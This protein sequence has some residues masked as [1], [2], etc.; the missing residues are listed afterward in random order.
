MN[1]S[2]NVIKKLNNAEFSF[3]VDW[4][5]IDESKFLELMTHKKSHLVENMAD[6]FAYFLKSPSTEVHKTIEEYILNHDLDAIDLAEKAGFITNVNVR[7]FPKTETIECQNTNDSVPFS[8]CLISEETKNTLKILSKDLPEDDY[9]ELKLELDKKNLYLYQEKNSLS[10]EVDEIKKKT[11]K[12]SVAASVLIASSL[13]AGFF[14]SPIIKSDIEKVFHKKSSIELSIKTINESSGKLSMAFSALNADLTDSVIN[15]YIPTLKELTSSEINDTISFVNKK[16]H[17]YGLELKE[18]AALSVDEKTQ[19]ILSILATAYGKDPSENMKSMASAIAIQSESHHLD[20]KMMLSIIKVESSF[21]QSVVSSTGDVSVA[22]VNYDHWSPEFKR[23]HYPNLDKEKLKNDVFYSVKIMA[24]ILA[25][26]SKGHQKDKLWYARYH[27][28]T[29]NKKI[30]YAKK[31][32]AE[33]HLIEETVALT[34][35]EKISNLIVELKNLK[36]SEKVAHEKVDEVI[37]NLTYLSSLI[38]WK[39]KEEL[40]IKLSRKNELLA[41]NEKNSSI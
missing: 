19:S 27:S 39:M 18:S 2:L 21:D 4:E 25:I 29:P 23:L 11:I 26:I 20:Y 32:S 22:Q 34:S 36:N 37:V 41:S 5:D 10:N 15:K 14:S 7:F 31:V 40:K 30:P 17:S 16:S 28:K 38:D 1:K 8:S 12:G 13:F 33:L 35:K 3:M 6:G 9:F 24:D